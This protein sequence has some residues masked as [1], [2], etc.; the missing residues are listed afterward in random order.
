MLSYVRLTQCICIYCIAACL[1]TFPPQT[2]KPANTCLSG[3]LRPC[4]WRVSWQ[5]LYQEAVFNIESLCHVINSFC[6]SLCK[7]EK[8]NR[9]ISITE[10][11]KNNPSNLLSLLI[12]LRIFAN[13][14]VSV[15]ALD[16]SVLCSNTYRVISFTTKVNINFPTN[17]MFNIPYLIA[18]YTRLS[19]LSPKSS[20]TTWT[21]HCLSLRRLIY[22]TF[23]LYTCTNVELLMPKTLSNKYYLRKSKD[24]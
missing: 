15:L 14:I 10:R 5:F 23:G 9:T 4:P 3:K 24:G 18:L 13:T 16:N 11:M 7:R 2:L 6:H 12:P 1:W 17:N 20:L 21:H 8:K 19:W 22:M